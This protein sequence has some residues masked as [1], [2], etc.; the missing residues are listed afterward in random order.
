MKRAILNKIHS[1]R[2]S[3]GFAVGREQIHVY[4][5]EEKKLLILGIPSIS[6]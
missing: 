4:D 1:V 3:Y 6:I 5:E 2:A